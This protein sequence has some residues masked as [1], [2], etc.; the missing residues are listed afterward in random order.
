MQELRRSPE[1][2]RK[3]GTVSIE[4]AAEVLGISRSAAY[5]AVRAR[6]SGDEGAWP[7]PIIRIGTRNRVPT[8]PLYQLIGVQ[9]QV[10]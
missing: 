10:I 1:T 7:T 3:P 5:E 6:L 9:V 8:V 4:E 2:V